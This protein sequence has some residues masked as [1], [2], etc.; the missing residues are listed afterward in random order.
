MAR[1][2]GVPEDKAGPMTKL[3]Y[4]LM[5]RGMKK[6]T[7][8]EPAH[9]NG[10]EPVEVWAVRPRMMMGM[11]FFNGAVRSG[12]AL[13]QR[14]KNLVEIKATQMIGCEYCVDLG[15]QICRNSG[16]SDDELLAVPRYQSSELFT[17]REKAALDYA[18]GVMRTP[19]EVS[20]ELFARV[21]RH[22][23]DQQLV[24]L[25]ALLTVVNLDR[26][27]AAFGIGSAGFS[28]GMVCLTP[29]RPATASATPTSTTAEAAEAGK[30]I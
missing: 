29:D 3:L 15:S 8:R 21:R 22:F 18:V 27:N 9:G 14:L 4:F 20:D 17:E 26:F 11:G 28:E 2:T 6:L 13:D 16:L 25:T 30:A 10:I 1:I 5:R 24:E 23:T 7:G 12:H 19:V